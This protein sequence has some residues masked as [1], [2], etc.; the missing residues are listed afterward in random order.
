[1]KK[2]CWKQIGVNEGS[3]TIPHTWHEK[4]RQTF[5]L[6]KFCPNKKSKDGLFFGK[7]RTVFYKD[8]LSYFRWNMI[9]TCFNEPIHFVSCS[10]Y[11]VTW[12][13]EHGKTW[14]CVKIINILNNET[15][16]CATLGYGIWPNK[17]EGRFIREQNSER[18]LEDWVCAFHGITSK[19]QRYILVNLCDFSPIT[20]GD[21][22]Q[23]WKRG[24]LGGDWVLKDA[25]QIVKEGYE[26]PFDDWEEFV[27]FHGGDNARTNAFR[28]L[29]H[30]KAL[31]FYEHSK[32][33]KNILMITGKFLMTLIIQTAFTVR[34]M[35]TIWKYRWSLPFHS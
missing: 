30:S 22:I 18:C 19:S 4:I 15:Q 35:R 17:I 27:K 26:L 31:N 24:H 3:I 20:W 23:K 10:N 9:I 8:G 33:G 21:L 5:V 6:K 34:C 32:H 1:M 7:L 29:Y 11:I 2:E 12:N 16:A 14:S 13:L 25:Q 28:Y